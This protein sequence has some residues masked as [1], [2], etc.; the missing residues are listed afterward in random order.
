MS[1]EIEDAPE[2]LLHVSGVAEVDEHEVGAGVEV[3]D[4]VA[5]IGEQPG[6]HAG[7]KSSD[8]PRI[9]QLGQRVGQVGTGGDAIGVFRE[10]CRH[11]RRHDLDDV[12]ESRGVDLGDLGEQFAQWFERVG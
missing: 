7:G 4:R 3:G 9:H 8:L 2:R 10:E 1:F 12:G 11:F 6:T 5:Q